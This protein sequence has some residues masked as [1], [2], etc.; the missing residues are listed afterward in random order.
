MWDDSV[1][2]AG[3]VEASAFLFEVVAPVGVEVAVGD[4]RTEFEDGFGSGQ[5]PSGAGD[6]HAVFDQVAAGSFDDPGGDRPA[7][8]QRGRVVQVGCLCGEVVGAGVGVLAFGR[9]VAGGLCKSPMSP[10]PMMGTPAADAPSTY[11]QIS[12]ELSETP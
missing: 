12:C 9:G 8:G 6:V 1:E 4:H 2:V 7:R 10:D 5:A 11:P 3:F